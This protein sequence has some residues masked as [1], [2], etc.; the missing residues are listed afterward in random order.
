MSPGPHYVNT[1]LLKIKFSFCL[2]CIL[3]TL[4]MFTFQL[5]I[6][7]QKQNE[8]YI[9]FLFIPLGGY[10]V[11]KLVSHY[12]IYRRIKYKDDGRELVNFADFVT[13]QMT[14]PA[15]NCWI[16]YQLLYSVFRA[17]AELCP[18]DNNIPAE[19]MLRNFCPDY[20]PTDMVVD[21][22]Q[23]QIMMYNWLVP[24]SIASTFIIFTEVSM[25]VAYYKDV[26]FGFV[27]LVNYAGMLMMTWQQ[28]DM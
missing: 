16:T 28:I 23:K 17:M 19:G 1:L 10:F 25:Y 13:I 22:A 11:L 8:Y 5:F 20:W 3:L 12:L 2:L 4:S 6:E 7:V 9:F 27:S 18:I 26:V 21:P 14:F 24:W 15:I